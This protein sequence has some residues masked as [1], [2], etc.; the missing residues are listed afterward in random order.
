MALNVNDIFLFT[1]FLTNKNLSGGISAKDLFFAWNPEQKSYLQDLL[2]RWQNRNNGKEGANTGLVQNETI[3]QKIAPFTKNVF[4]DCEIGGTG[5]LAY[6]PDDFVYR[7]GTRINDQP[8]YQTNPSQ[9]WSVKSSVID[10]PS[11]TDETYYFTAYENYYQILPTDLLIV[12][13]IQLELDYVRQPADIVWGYT[14]APNGQQIYNAGTSVQPEW[15]DEDIIEITK[16]TLKALGVRFKD[17]DFQN[18]GNSNIV[19]GD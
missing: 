15:K 19:T 14:T 1:R 5:V 6:L 16:R 4:I 12:D 3:M 10:P 2:G 8:V 7:L 9:L 17:A 11:R 18:F 13:Q